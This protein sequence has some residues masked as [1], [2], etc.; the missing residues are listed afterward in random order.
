ME[1]GNRFFS[2]FALPAALKDFEQQSWYIVAGLMCRRFTSHW[3]NNRTTGEVELNHGKS[4]EPRM[5]PEKKLVYQVFVLL[6]THV[7][8]Q[9][10][11]SFALDYVLSIRE[12]LDI[13]LMR[14]GLEKDMTDAH[15]TSADDI[16]ASLDEVYNKPIYSA[17]IDP[18]RK[19]GDDKGELEKE[20]A[21]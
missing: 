15:Q 19:D 3:Y 6:Q 10:R 7:V 18:T 4:V 12:K 16:L 17:G 9:E 21:A 11:N 8:Q 5:T 13:D 14:P 1:H 2:E 20:E